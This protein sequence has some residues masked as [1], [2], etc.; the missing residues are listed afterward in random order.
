MP[1]FVVFSESFCSCSRRVSTLAL[2]LVPSYPLVL[3][4]AETRKPGAIS[5][6][7]IA[8]I[9]PALFISSSSWLGDLK[10]IR[11]SGP[12]SPNQ[13]HVKLDGSSTPGARKISVGRA[14]EVRVEATK[15][16]AV[17]GIEEVCA[18]L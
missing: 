4:P 6:R 13:L 14:V 1:V 11:A 15:A 17:K 5:Q 7:L 16:D 3:S 12:A 9:F 8:P 18:K 10:G 2:L